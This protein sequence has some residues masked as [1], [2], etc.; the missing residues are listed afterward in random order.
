[1][2]TALI[3]QNTTDSISQP[4]LYVAASGTPAYP[5]V[6]AMLLVG[7]AKFLG[8]HMLPDG[9]HVLTVFLPGSRTRSNPPEL[10]PEGRKISISR[11]F[12]VTALRDYENWREKYF[13]EAIQNS[14][15][16][17][18]TQIDITSKQN[19]DG[20]WTV[21]VTDDGGGMSEDVLL[22]KFLVLGG[23]TKVGVAGSAGGFGKA[24]ELLVLPWLSWKIH[25][26][27]IEAAGSGIEYTIKRVEMIHGTVLEVIMPNDN[28][29]DTPQAISMIEKSYLPKISFTV[30]GSKFKADLKAS[31]EPIEVIGNKAE[32]YFVKADNARSL[33][34]MLVRTKGLFMFEIYIGD[35]IPGYVIAE[36]TAPSIEILT[37]NRDGF[38]DY[39]VKREIAKFGERVAKDTLS[40]LRS[41]KG[42]IR[43]KF[44][45]TGKFKAKQ[46]AADAIVAV[47]PI[48]EPKNKSGS[49]LSDAAVER[50]AAVLADRDER[51]SVGAVSV[52]TARVML[53]TR[54]LGSD[55]AE[56]MVKQLVWQ[57]DFYIVNDIENFKV[58][59]KFFPETMTPTVRKIAATWT[60]MC[61]FVLIQ[62][63]SDS[64]FGVGFIFSESTLAGYLSDND[65]GESGQWLMLNPF[66]K[67]QSRDMMWSPSHTADL[68]WLY[69]AAIHEATHMA[70]GISY[71]DEAFAA[72]LTKNMAKC[73]DG[74]RKIKQIVGSIRMRGSLEADT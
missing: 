28:H 73:A 35:A 66:K 47:G 59:K 63:G 10:S 18:A 57:P 21:T 29:A 15:D 58:P 32:L 13:R 2:E 37:A 16:A 71:H 50:V 45:G 8:E 72:A 67:L 38:R 42:L 64:E 34:Y 24:K 36:L 53:S 4:G 12:F 40:A 62:L 26:R 60:E 14:Y 49:Q 44:V 46:M 51:D 23:T 39:Q 41:K 69:A 6:Q 5:I 74:F 33:S 55:H 65:E 48:H 56:S 17:G 61:R 20:T 1:M 9:T 22:N 27:D 11:E 52:D 19:A 3:L 70:D 7:K 31:G 30:N 68:Q 43:Q 54:I 25:S